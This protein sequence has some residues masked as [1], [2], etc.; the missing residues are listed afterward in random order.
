MTFQY[1][2]DPIIQSSH[3]VAISQIDHL[4]I[5]L[6]KLMKGPFAV[7]LGLSFAFNMQEAIAIKR[8]RLNTHLTQQIEAILNTSQLLHQSLIQNDHDKMEAHLTHIKHLIVSAKQTS[9]KEASNTLH[10]RHI[11]NNTERALEQVG[12]YTQEKQKKQ[13]IKTMFDQFVLLSQTYQF[14]SN[15]PIYFCAKDKSVWLQKVGKI[16]NPI[17]SHY[18]HC[19]SIVN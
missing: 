13:K 10:L 5:W 2:T 18:I 12:L 6:Y 11:L 14:S 8:I 7:V 4:T 15:Y 1:T 9:Y 19:G 17:H 3:N 16:R